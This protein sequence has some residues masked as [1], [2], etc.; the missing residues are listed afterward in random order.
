MD[1]SLHALCEALKK[2]IFQLKPQHQA[3]SFLLLTGRNKQGK[4]TLLRQSQLE[5]MSVDSELSAD[6]YYNPQGL[7][8][9]L[10][11]SWL[12]QSNH[13]L[14]YT[15]KQLNH[16][17]RALKISGI[18][19]C[20]DLHELLISD[21]IACAEHCKTHTQLLAK[22]GHSLNYK[23]PAALLLTQ[24]D[25]LAGFCEFF[26]NEHVSDL[27][28]PLGFSLDWATRDGK[29]LHN[30]KAQFEQLIDVLGQQVIQKMHPARS[31]IKR[32]LIREFPLQVASLG[33][34]IQTLMQQ[35]SPKSFRLKALYLTSG[36][37]GGVSVDRV[38][39]KI[40]HEYALTIQ[41]NFPQ[42]INHR[43]Y[44]IEGA[45]VAFQNITKCRPSSI[46]V[47]PK[48][49]TS[50]LIGLVALSFGWLGIEHVKSSR[51]LDKASK[52]LL[53]YDTLGRVQNGDASSALY[54]LT[55]ASSTLDKLSSN[56]LSLPTIQTLKNQLNAQT[57]QH[58]QG[59][60]LPT[61]LAEIEQTILDTRLTQADRYDALKIYL[62]LG[63][64][65]RF[66]PSDVLA[67]FR[68]TWQQAPA[69]VLENK[70]S[71]IK[72]VF[73][74][75]FQ[76][77]PINHQIV[78]DV[79]N[80]L[81]ALPANY[82][83]YSL[84]KGSFPKEREA[85][86]INGFELSDKEI[87]VM[88]SKSGFKQ[89]VSALP[90][91]SAQLQ[92][93]NWVLARQDLAHLPTLL[94]QAY[95]Y[96]YVLWWQN[97]MRKSAPL[98]VQDYQQA[99]LLMHS[100]HLANTINKLL[101]LILQNTSPELGENATLFNQEI[102]SKFTQL[103][104]M[105]QTAIR[106]LS[107]NLNELEKFITTLSMVHDQGKTAFTITKSRF[108]GD[109]LS[110][111]IS[112]LY[113]ETRQLPEPVATWVKQMADDTWF[114]LISDSKTYLNQQWQQLVV[115][116]YQYTI[117]K[118]YPL[119]ITKTQE[120]TIADFDRFFSPHGR[121]NT[122]VEQYLKPFIDTSQAQ[123]QLKEL[124]HYVL[125]I[126][127]D[128]VNELIRANVITNMFFPELG[129]TSKIDFSLQKLNLDPVLSNLELMIGSTQ[130]KDTQ[131]SDSPVNF[132]WPQTNA[133][134]SL[135][136]IEGRHYEIDETGPWAFFKM[137][138][139]VNVLVDEQ[140]SSS[141]QI[142]FEINGNS[143]R[144]VLKTKNQ[145]NPFIPGILNGFS[146]NDSIA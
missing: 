67:W 4:S 114:I 19:L 132:H 128:M 6:I 95:C 146:L 106:E 100:L 121:L 69:D 63:D 142:L 25:A 117:A 96:E 58:L 10:G 12:N 21:P 119:D 61:I 98:H 16:C 68:K 59:N 102:A 22:F 52:E 129:E 85:I 37:Q 101:E 45:L 115:Q 41:E 71:L 79:R 84:A 3:L 104:L 105:S 65:S 137:L 135:N 120:V 1:K 88:F 74:Q 92:T 40:Q 49:V 144:Y 39:K 108:E 31:N 99:S 143:G 55:M 139:K 20:V 42:S 89:I 141:L 62:M 94:Q 9:E 11:E 70:L 36:E 97:F 53:T 30:F 123:W 134:L 18:I 54:H 34:V 112:A 24:L 83:Y 103:S 113:A 14:Q 17:H 130:L 7:I 124:N 26:Q 111:P 46:S 107:T 44:F 78:S 116:D 47:S 15:L 145:I 87:P 2:V 76:P 8:V 125:P 13:L 35:M 64:P 48:W 66:S 131:D 80:Y 28:K 43:A 77:V 51:L 133:K 109:S 50:T 81:N 38:C 126:S 29:Y 118:R 57:K 27:K 122:F 72:Q 5:H 32:T 136:S 90:E 91:I 138:Q 33:R 86:N 73:Q 23:I 110:N 127:P 82:L 75:P 140:D 60:F 93:D 56:S